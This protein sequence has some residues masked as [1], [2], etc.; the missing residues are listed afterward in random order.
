VRRRRLHAICLATG[1][2]IAGS[3]I[4]GCPGETGA[5]AGT[6]APGDVQILAFTVQPAALTAG[7]ST[8][9]SWETTQASGC[10]IE[11]D[12]G[13]VPRAG[14]LDLVPA[15]S[16]TWTLACEGTGGPVSETASVTVTGE[17]P[18]A[19]TGADASVDAGADAGY[20][21]G[22]D[23][24]FDAGHIVVGGNGEQIDLPASVVEGALAR[25]GM[26]AFWEHRDLTLN[27]DLRCDAH[28][29]A[30][31]DGNTHS[32]GCVIPAG[33]RVD[34]IYAQF[35][36]PADAGPDAG[37]P[38]ATIEF[39]REV[40][41]ILHDTITLNAAQP[42]LARSDVEYPMS[43]DGLGLGPTNDTL[44]LSSD[45]RSVDFH[46][47]GD[48]DVIRVV[49]YARGQDPVRI[50]SPSIRWADVPD[51]G[52]IVEGRFESDTRLT[53]FAEADGLV[54]DAGLGVDTAGVG[55]FGGG[56]V[57][58]GAALASGEVVD[59]VLVQL[60]SVDRPDAG[61]QRVGG[62]FTFERRVLG[63]IGTDTF[64]DDAEAAYDALVTSGDDLELDDNDIVQVYEDE[65]SMRVSLSV[66][67]TGLDHMRVILEAP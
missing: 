44:R 31:H 12:V 27:A 36:P 40:A 6:P 19:G 42:M 62:T 56:A 1:C 47:G 18:D 65:R 64:A 29:P 35:D 22:Y 66:V 41:A 2:L 51:G 34:V 52:A 25:N 43:V 5:D 15:A 20:D 8:T 9:L 16:T 37:L 28:V 26:V 59:V 14:T 63:W 11:P 58:T 39:P 54:L 46:T 24:G 60:D 4:A 33:T 57:P 53:V 13:R 10:A 23:G 38:D 49:M 3:L 67:S 55:L 50:V 21:A 45:R 7:E 32:L 30:L 61:S 48:I 17:L